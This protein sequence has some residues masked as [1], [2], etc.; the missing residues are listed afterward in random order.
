MQNG[1]VLIVDDESINRLL[2]KSYLQRDYDILEAENGE[3]AI[4]RL[5]QYGEQISVVLLDLLMPKKDG[6]EVLKHMN[7]Y[8]YITAI[9]VVLITGAANVDNEKR[10]F[11]EGVSDFIAKPFSQVLV[12][13]RVKN[14][15]N[16]FQRTNELQRLVQEQTEEVYIQSELLREQIIKDKRNSDI[17][18]DGLSS[19]VEF[20]SIESGEHISR[21]KKLTRVL[22]NKLAQREPSLPITEEEIRTV[23]RASALHDIGKIAIPDNI[24]LKPGP[25]SE[26]EF[27]I[28]KKH[29]VYG[30]NILEHF[31]ELSDKKFL[32]YA[33]EICL[34]HHERV[35]GRG[36]PDGLVGDAIP[37]YVQIVSIA[38][39]YD[40]LVSPRIYKKSFSTEKAMHMIIN[41]ECGAFSERIISLLK[42]AQEEIEQIYM[43]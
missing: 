16:L 32:E 33:Y 41:Q 24:L 3:E 27:D 11:D 13:K 36:Y 37:I 5:G 35:D 42:S 28:M 25:L 20:R 39:V 4:D 30:I 17:L 15:I 12:E 38:D 29:A 6:F 34:H 43:E 9:P 2:L 1:I 7:E 8:G 14:V 22:Y 23:E 18:I 10:A 19:V 21:I 40:A 26:K 31:K